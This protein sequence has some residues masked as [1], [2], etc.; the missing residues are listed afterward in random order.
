MKVSEVLRLHDDGWRLVATKGSHCRRP[1]STRA[2]L[3]EVEAEIRE[4]I[5]LHLDGM[6]EDGVPIPTPQ[7]NVYCVEDSA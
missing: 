5:E 2:S 4:A 1:R 3:E 6:R 7:S